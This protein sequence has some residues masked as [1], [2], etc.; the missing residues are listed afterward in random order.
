MKAAPL[1]K[2]LCKDSFTW[3]DEAIE[4]FNKLK[5]ALTTTPVLQLPDFSQEFTVKTDAS[6]FAMGAVLTQKKRP[7]AYFSK[8]FPPSVRH[9]SAYVKEMV[10]IVEAVKKWKHYR[11]CQRFT[12]ITDHNS[13]R[14]L[15]I[16]QIQTPAQQ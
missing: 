5:E 13:L 14:H 7:L 11:T 15:V 10:A 6:G 3:H 2:L 4:S 16:Q 8:Q 1:T 12:I 9:S